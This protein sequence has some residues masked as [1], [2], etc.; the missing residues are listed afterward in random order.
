MHYTIT[1][2]SLQVYC[3]QR[4]QEGVWDYNWHS[5]IKIAGG[6]GVEFTT[7]I[8]KSTQKPNAI[9]SF[10]RWVIM[11]FMI[12]SSEHPGILDF[13]LPLSLDYQGQSYN[14]VESIFY[15]AKSC[16]ISNISNSLQPGDPWACRKSCLQFW[17]K[18][19]L[20]PILYSQKKDYWDFKGIDS[21]KPN[22]RQ[23]RKHA[24]HRMYETSKTT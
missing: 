8:Q 1:S 9:F 15:L 11:E 17:Q 5:E 21:L 24:L 6:W 3:S 4:Y 13:Q 7:N 12:I 18:A 14:K 16:V 2:L 19:P 22:L 10:L 23:M 20:T